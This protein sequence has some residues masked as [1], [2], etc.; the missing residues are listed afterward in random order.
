MIKDILENID[1]ADLS[2]ET[3]DIISEAFDKAVADKAE[4]LA[5]EKMNETFDVKV[6]EKSLEI[7]D[8]VE[9]GYKTYLEESE[10]KINEEAVEFKTSLIETIDA[11]M[12]QYVDEMVSENSGDMEKDITIAKA[13]AIISSFEKLGLEVKTEQMDENAQT[14]QAE[15]EKLEA[16]VNELVNENIKLKDDAIEAEKATIVETKSANL[17]EIQKEK[18]IKLAETFDNI[19]DVE[20]FEKKL[21][22]VVES[23]ETP[24]VAEVTKE[25]IKVV[26]ESKENKDNNFI[27]RFL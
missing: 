23:F 22:I 14:R 21:D 20:E 15:V 8:K 3:Q 10:D 9:A 17:S 19:K 25:E 27:S 5:E 12:K 13:D 26:E 24:A 7:V 18:L 11:Y 1:S 6:A 16:K 4:A 2:K